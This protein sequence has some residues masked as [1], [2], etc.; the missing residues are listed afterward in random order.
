MA[1]SR[2]GGSPC[3]SVDTKNGPVSRIG[4]SGGSSGRGAGPRPRADGQSNADICALAAFRPTVS[5]V[6]STG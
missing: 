2:G 6:L 3:C 4:L 5:V 1:S